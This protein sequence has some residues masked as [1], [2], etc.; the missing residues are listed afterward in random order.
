MNIA[1][2]LKKCP[3]GMKLYSPVYGE[4][5]LED[6]RNGQNFSIYCITENGGLDAFTSDGRI[7]SEYPHA[8]CVLFPS[9]DQRDWNKF[10]VPDQV[11][12]TEPDTEPDQKHRFKPFDKVLVRV[13]DNYTWSCDLFNYIDETEGVYVGIGSVGSQCIPYEGNEHLLG[14][15]NNPE[16]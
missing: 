9:R 16:E 11:P 15:K 10:I 12:D 5:K 7:Y 14:T 13:G 4:V 2:I 1:E 3:K 6:V 8:E